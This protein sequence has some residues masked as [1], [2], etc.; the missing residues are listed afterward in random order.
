MQ[1][2]FP[3]PNAAPGIPRVSDLCILPLAVPIAAAG[4]ALRNK[5]PFAAGAFVE[6]GAGVGTPP[7]ARLMPG[8]EPG[9]LRLDVR[10]AVRFARLF[11]ALPAAPEPGPRTVLFN[12]RWRMPEGAPLTHIG[13]ART[14]PGRGWQWMSGTQRRLGAARDWRDTSA[15]W[16]DIPQEGPPA[17][18]MLQCDGPVVI[19]FATLRVAVTATDAA[20]LPAPSGLD[21]LLAAGA[22]SD[23][24]EDRVPAGRPNEGKTSAAFAMRWLADGRL[25][26]RARLEGCLDGVLDR[27]AADLM[28]DGLLLHAGRL[29]PAEHGGWQFAV[30]LACSARTAGRRL[31]L[32]LPRI[33]SGFDLP[34][35]DEPATPAPPPLL[36][37]AGLAE[38]A[39]EGLRP[40]SSG[41]VKVVGWA[42]DPAQ[43]DAAVG[44]D[45]FADGTPLASGWATGHRR[46]IATAPGGLGV[47]GFAIELPANF[48]RGRTITLEARARSERG[49]LMPGTLELTLPPHG[50][51]PEP[52]IET[53]LPL[54]VAPLPPAGPTPSAAAVI[55]TEDGAEILGPMLESLVRFEPGAF[56]RI[57]VV[58]HE[59][60]DSTATLIERYAD[61]LPLQHVRQPRGAS[62]AASCNLG[63]RLCEEDVLVF[64]NNDL[65]FMAPML[66]GI[67]ARAQPGAGA[68]GAQLLD[69]PAGR[70]APIPQHL[71][72]HI[73]PG[74]T[75]IRPFETRRQDEAPAAATAAVLVPAVT[76]ALLAIHRLSFAALGGFD[77]GYFYGL[78]DVDLCLRALAGGRANVA[79]NTARALH[80]RGHS[81]RRADPGGRL[82][83]AGN[84]LRFARDWAPALRHA[85]RAGQLTG[86][87]FWTGRKLN[88]GY[89]VKEVGDEP[90]GEDWRMA[91]GLAHALERLLPCNGHF[92]RAADPLD[93]TD[94]DLIVVLDPAFDPRLMRG[95]GAA[96]LLIAWAHGAFPHWAGHPGRE[97]FDAWFAASPLGRNYLAEELGRRVDV[98]PPATDPARFAAR[99]ADADA[100]CDIA[101]WVDDPRGA[102]MATSLLPALSAHRVRLFGPGDALDL[103]QGM[104]APRIVVDVADPQAAAWGILHPRVLDALAAGVAVLTSNRAAAEALPPGLLPVFDGPADLALQA[105]ALLSNVA[106]P[107]AQAARAA[108][109]TH[110]GFDARAAALL[111]A[112]RAR[113][114]A[115]LQVAIKTGAEPPLVSMAEALRR[116][117]GALGHAVRIDAPGMWHGPRTAADDAV[118]ALPG[119]ARFVPRPDQIG[120][121]WA[122][123]DFERLS[124]HEI[125]GFDMAF[126]ASP[127]AVAQFGPFARLP[128]RLLAFAEDA[129]PTTGLTAQATVL[130]QCLRACHAAR[131]VL[132][133]TPDLDART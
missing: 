34:P 130:D 106:E 95:A 25:S 79:V 131:N 111:T 54:L 22:F 105:R 27:E 112:L 21:V 49:G 7:E 69:D 66:A 129:D 38:G 87:G 78:E 119:A 88:I 18:L 123:R 20:A 1:N 101:I 4:V 125:D 32:R 8:D 126:L 48:A 98:L 72:I 117:L 63:A 33:G 28:A 93:A 2:A 132:P 5:V 39:L 108:I 55:L 92:F 58:D 124:L 75:V 120:L 24:P 97:L 29:R 102:A 16:G 13:L 3:N 46:D 77:E 11:I 44:V 115:G 57:V 30:D 103:S 41:A 50:I 122:V 61:R 83:R 31:H 74:A 82:R 23:R 128:P 52:E 56:R 26:I 12:A 65:V 10:G 114:A 60:T 86:T 100:D 67:I 6:L 45:L 68:I 104:A 14:E 64:L 94:L 96:S 89:V 116:A 133:P 43:P 59:S 71:G 118:I 121:L 53:T 62:F 109:R 99:R 42:R 73:E 91:R 40:H 37:Q 47:G 84:P 90:S 80:L 15:S 70:D 19:E 113:V 9:V 51:R 35:M 81:R 110:H 127:G 85:I 36:A 17:H 76:G 107:S